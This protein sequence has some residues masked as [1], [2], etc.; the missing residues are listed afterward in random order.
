MKILSLVLSVAVFFTSGYFFITDFRASTDMNYLI[1]MSLLAI[2]MLI[3]IVGVM[4]N[5]PLLLRSR[6]KVRSLIYNSYSKERVRNKQFDSSFD[7]L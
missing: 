1:Y 7:L 4:I 3:C 5:L 6:R 2:L